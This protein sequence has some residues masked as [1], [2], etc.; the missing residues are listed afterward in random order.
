[1]GSGPTAS[2]NKG[3]EKP[4]EPSTNMEPTPKK[5]EPEFKKLCFGEKFAE[6][7][8]YNGDPNLTNS[9]EKNQ[10]QQLWDEMIQSSP[11]IAKGLC[12]YY[13]KNH[14]TFLK[15]L[16]KG[17]PCKYRWEAW[18]TVLNIEKIYEND[19]YSQLIKSSQNKIDKYHKQIQADS[20]Y[21]FLNE[22]SSNQNNETLEDRKSVV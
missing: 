14:D 6:D 17:P 15:N 20:Q 16:K 8:L 21:M 10:Q 22:F 11:N 18:K 19:M 7:A 3:K 5:K 13:S 1:M 4:N 12:D 2:T 9:D